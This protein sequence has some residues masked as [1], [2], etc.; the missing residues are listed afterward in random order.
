MVS[1]VWLHYPFE[2]N[3]DDWMEFEDLDE[4]VTND[5]VDDVN[6]IV[7]E[8]GFTNS[9]TEISNEKICYGYYCDFIKDGHVIEVEC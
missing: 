2:K 7:K 4:V 1:K 3:H 6:G 8:L 9:I 5:K